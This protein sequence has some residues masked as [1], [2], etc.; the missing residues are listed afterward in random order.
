MPEII[1][2]YDKTVGVLD[3]EQGLVVSWLLPN[4]ALQSA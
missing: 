4:H 2:I 3:S 1:R